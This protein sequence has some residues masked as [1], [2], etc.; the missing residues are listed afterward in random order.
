MLRRTGSILPTRLMAHLRAANCSLR[1]TTHVRL[2]AAKQRRI[3][4]PSVNRLMGT[5]NC[6]IT[7][8]G[9]RGR[10]GRRPR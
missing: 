10:A 1:Q 5:A 9:V 6:I 2:V 3:N 7:C 8:T 4:R